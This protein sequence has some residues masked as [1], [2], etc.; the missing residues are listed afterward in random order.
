VVRSDVSGAH[1][2]PLSARVLSTASHQVKA[3]TP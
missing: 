1:R 2:L 3:E